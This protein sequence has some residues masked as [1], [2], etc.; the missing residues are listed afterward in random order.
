MRRRDEDKQQRVKEAIVNVMLR[1]GL[2]GA[3][4]SKIA[5]EAGVSPATIYVY[6]AN[7]D[8]MLAEVFKEYSG[9]AYSCLMDSIRPDMNGRELIEAIVRGFYDYSVE[10]EEAFSFVEQCSRCP[11]L[12]QTVCE[13]ECCCEVLGVLHDYQDKGIVKKYSDPILFMMLFSPV[14]C[15]AQNRGNMPCDPDK[16]LNELVDALSD[17]LLL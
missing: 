16:V 15:L 9:Q 12:A 5:Q 10:H 2:N 6:Y 17:L 13:S 1:D 4:V 7:K 3:S 11:S 14:R 8:E